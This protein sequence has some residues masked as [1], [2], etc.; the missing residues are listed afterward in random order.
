MFAHGKLV[1][2]LALLALTPLA[3]SEV[4]VFHMVITDRT[5]PQNVQTRE[6]KTSL[7]PFQWVAFY[8][9]K[10]TESLD[11]KDTWICPD[12]TSD[13]YEYCPSPR[14]KT[15]PSTSNPESAPPPP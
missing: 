3:R 8:P 5:D 12:D 1:F 4:R 11:Y 9:L 7:D 6:F 10:S 13:D 15:E 2:C 14:A